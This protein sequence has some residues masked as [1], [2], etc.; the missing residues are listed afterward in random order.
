[1]KIQA[2]MLLNFSDGVHAIVIILLLTLFGFDSIGKVKLNPFE[3]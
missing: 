2:P 1:M 3:Y